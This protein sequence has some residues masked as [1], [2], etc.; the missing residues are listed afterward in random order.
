MIEEDLLIERH[1]EPDALRSVDARLRD[2]GV[3][4]WAII[5]YLRV[6]GNDVNQVALDY[7]VSVDAVRAALAHYARHRELI[8][9][10]LALNAA[11]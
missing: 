1:V 9:A 6:V 2:S 5:G 8:D 11:L 7:D 3:P 10:K 4:I